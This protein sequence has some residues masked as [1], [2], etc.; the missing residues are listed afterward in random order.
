VK[1]QQPLLVILDLVKT[2]V[3]VLLIPPNL[4]VTPVLAQVAGLDQLAVLHQPLPVLPIQLFV[5][6]MEFVF[7]LLILMPLFLLFNVFV[8]GDILE[9]NAPMPLLLVLQL[10]A[11][12]EESV[13]DL[14]PLLVSNLPV[15]VLNLG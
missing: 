4:E 15:C 2:L 14:T 8:C 9:T 7:H 13:L 11:K 5:P 12:M 3:Y 1:F 6:P 10:L